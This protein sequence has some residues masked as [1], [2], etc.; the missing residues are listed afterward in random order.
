M[1]KEDK[2]FEARKKAREILDNAERV[3]RSL[4][5]DNKDNNVQILSEAVGE[6]NEISQKHKL[7]LDISR[8]DFICN[9]I[10]NIDKNVSDKIKID[11]KVHSEILDSIKL[12]N[13]KLDGYP[14]IK[15]AV[16]GACG[17]LASA[18]FY[19]LIKKNV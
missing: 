7:L 6:V 16:I 5:L 4:I 18:T 1:K 11:E 19:F 13:K 8:L 17:L 14:L 15:N 10:D 9:R 12:I 3:A 2:L